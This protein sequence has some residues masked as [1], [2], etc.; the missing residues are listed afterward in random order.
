MSG[1]EGVDARSF[2]RRRGPRVVLSVP[3]HVSKGA[4]GS[5]GTVSHY[6]AQSRDLSVGGVY[7]T[8]TEGG[9]FVPGELVEVSITVPWEARRVFQIGRAHV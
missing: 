3:V 8:I 5:G 2:E 6:T 1:L 9:T 7:V 4:G